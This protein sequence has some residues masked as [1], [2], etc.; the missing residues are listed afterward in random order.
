VQSHIV[1]N[2]LENIKALCTKTGLVQALRRYYKGL[3]EARTF[4]YTVHDSIPTSYIVMSHYEDSEF[5]S[6]VARHKELEIG[7]YDNERVPAKHCREN[8]WLVKPA[9]LNQ[10]RGIQIF[11][12]SLVELCTFLKSKPPFTYWV[13]QKYIERPLLY[14][15]RKFDL[16]VWALVTWKTELFYY[17]IGYIRTTSHLYTLNSRV[18]YV[19]LTN[20]CL[21]KYGD[22][23][24]AF[25]AG[26]TLGFDTLKKYIRANSNGVE[27]NFESDIVG[28]IKDL[29]IDAYV[30]VVNELNPTKRRNCFELLG[31]DFLIDEDFRVWLIEVNSNP[32]IEMPNQYIEGLLPKMLNDMFEIV[33][34][35]HVLLLNSLPPKGRTSVRNSVD[36]ENQ[37]ELLYDKHKKYNARRSFASPIYPWHKSS[38]SLA[39][40]KL[41]SEVSKL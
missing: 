32:Y 12:N 29:M 22:K 34:D 11:K 17:R 6:F 30:S 40:H 18:N 2:H 33:L 41:V 25:E 1:I 8:V 31:F 14:Y 28:R 37:F 10:G 27:V 7:Y 26:N 21:Q 23:Y 36:L 5:K 3:G 13:V 39:I 24:G 15:G 4:Q 38:A 16:R 9:A 35:P 19:H 20:N